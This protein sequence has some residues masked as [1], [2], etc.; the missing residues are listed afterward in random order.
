MCEINFIFLLN[1]PRI[2]CLSDG[3]GAVNDKATL[4]VVMLKVVEES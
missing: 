1:M 4:L 2:T 3:S